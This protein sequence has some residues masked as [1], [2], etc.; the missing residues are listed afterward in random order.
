[1]EIKTALRALGG[2]AQ[3]TRLGI[4]RLLVEE[5]PEGLPA[6]EIVQ[7]LELA[8]ATAS[9]HLKELTH[10]ELVT[11]RQAGRFIYYSANYNTMNGL[12]AYLTENCCKGSTCDVACAPVAAKRK[13]SLS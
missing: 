13:R 2:L 10:A 3:D 7:R 4:F 8:N 5:G 11:P 9:F 6:G 12:V 1:M